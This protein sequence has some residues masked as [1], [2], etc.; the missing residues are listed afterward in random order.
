[1]VTFLIFVAISLLLVFPVLYFLLH[2]SLGNSI[3]LAFLS[4][5]LVQVLFI[6]LNRVVACF[7]LDDRSI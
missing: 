1:M 5:F 2:L 3:L 6:L 4:F 7:T